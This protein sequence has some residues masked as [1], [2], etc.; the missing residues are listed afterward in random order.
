MPLWAG[1]FVA[2]HQNDGLS[3]LAGGPACVSAQ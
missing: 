2:V 1:P 3:Q